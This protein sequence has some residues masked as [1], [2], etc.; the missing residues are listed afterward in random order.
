MYP[1]FINGSI[2]YKRVPSP[3]PPPICSGRW[4]LE[5]GQIGLGQLALLWLLLCHLRSW[6]LCA[7]EMMVS[8]LF[9]Q[10]RSQNIRYNKTYL[11]LL[12]RASL[13]C[14]EQACFTCAGLQ[15]SS[16]L[17]QEKWN[18]ENVLQWQKIGIPLSGSCSWWYWSKEGLQVACLWLFP[19]FLK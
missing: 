10:K 2:L 6:V 9:S 12:W 16:H 1:A 4:E 11:E 8:F 5:G 3:R 19:N 17:C 13:V 7:K 14:S 15:S 18:W